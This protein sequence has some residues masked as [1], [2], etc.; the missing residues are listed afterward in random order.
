MVVMDLM[1][2]FKSLTKLFLPSHHNLYHNSLPEFQISNKKFVV[3][4]N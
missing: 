2:E 4:K 1:V 3:Y